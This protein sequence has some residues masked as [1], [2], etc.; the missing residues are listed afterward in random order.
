MSTQEI[1]SV[2]HVLSMRDLPAVW[3]ELTLV[4]SGSG[5]VPPK[6]KDAEQ[7]MKKVADALYNLNIKKDSLW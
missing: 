7:L 6:R 5:L 4:S 3:Q 1:P 2:L